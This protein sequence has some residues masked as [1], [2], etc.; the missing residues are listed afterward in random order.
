[1]RRRLVVLGTVVLSILGVGSF[2]LATTSCGSVVGGGGCPG[3][4]IVSCTEP[5]PIDC[6]AEGETETCVGPDFFDNPGFGDNERC[7]FCE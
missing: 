7:C 6:S 2:G 4:V 5:C 1:M 3:A